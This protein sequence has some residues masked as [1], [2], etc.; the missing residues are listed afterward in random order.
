[1]DRAAF[2]VDVGDVELVELRYGV[3]GV[4]D[5]G[6]HSRGTDG[7][8]GIGAGGPSYGEDAQQLVGLLGIQAVAVPGCRVGPVQAGEG[9]VVDE[10]VVRLDTGALGVVRRGGV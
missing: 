2:Q 8:G 4:C 7:G 10:G 6:C 1:G 3:A 9:E 5:K